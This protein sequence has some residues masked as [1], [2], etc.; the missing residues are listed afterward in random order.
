MKTVQKSIKL[1][2]RL[3]LTSFIANLQKNLI[4]TTKEQSLGSVCFEN[5]LT[6]FIKYKLSP[7]HKILHENCTKKHQTFTEVATN[8]FHCKSTKK[9]NQ[10]DQGTKFRFSL[11]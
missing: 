5:Q 8:Q 11:L 6:F 2:Q 4:K 3:Q 9:S 10:N 7:K 1:S